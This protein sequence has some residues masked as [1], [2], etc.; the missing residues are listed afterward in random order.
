[1]L[2]SRLSHSRPL[3]FQGESTAVLA[4][5]SVSSTDTLIDEHL[6]LA[7]HVATSY[8]GRGIEVDDL[9]QVARLALVKAARGYDPER[10]S[11][12]PY[13]TVTIR[14]ELRRHFRDHAWAIRPPRRIQELHAALMNEL[15]SDPQQRD[16]RRLAR[17]VG[18]EVDDVREA[19]RAPDYFTAASLDATDTGAQRL[20]SADERLDHIDQW[21]VLRSM[22]SRLTTADRRLL[23]WR[24]VD[25]LTQQQIASRFGISQV[26]VSRRLS[27]LLARLRAEATLDETAA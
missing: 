24:F 12:V 23:Y 18:A 9:V 16:A 27:R 22:W 25:E 7:T 15:E 1:M 4:D 6:P 17:R 5:A 3:R 13:A 19:M 10:G 14:G 26:Q 2:D 20:G 8:R 11:F 21:M